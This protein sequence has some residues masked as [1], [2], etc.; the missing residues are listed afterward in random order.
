MTSNPYVTAQLTANGPD[1]R[2]ELHATPYNGCQELDGS[3][4]LDVSEAVILWGNDSVDQG[5]KIQK[6]AQSSN[7]TRD[8]RGTGIVRK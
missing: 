6:R 1:Y 2:G 8:E 7:W 3:G 5:S 4:L